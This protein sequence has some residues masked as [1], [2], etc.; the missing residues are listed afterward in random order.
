MD[1]ALAISGADK[2]KETGQQLVKRWFEHDPA[3]AFG[4]L[5]NSRNLS[6]EEKQE[7]LRK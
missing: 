7:I 6:P 5:E 4:W 2:R 1:W 3:A